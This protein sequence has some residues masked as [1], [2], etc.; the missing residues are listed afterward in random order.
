MKI[1]KT[2]SIALA[3][4]MMAGLP[5]ITKPAIAQGAAAPSAAQRQAEITFWTSIKDSKN[6]EEYKAYLEAFPN[7][8]FAALARLRIKQL[9]SAPAAPSAPP[10]AAPP[11][12][13]QPSAPPPPPQTAQPPAPPPP[14]TEPPKTA[15]PP[16]APPAPPPTVAGPPEPEA[17]PPSANEP[18]A[19][20]PA[21]PPPS[22]SPPV[23]QA[24][25]APPQQTSRIDYTN[26]EFLRELQQKLYDLNYAVSRVTGVFDADTYKSILAV[27]RN[28]RHPQ[29]GELTESE[30][31]AIQRARASNVWGAIA[32]N[33]NST[34]AFVYKR[35]SRSEAES[36]AR[37][38]CLRRAGRKAKCLILAAKDNQCIAMAKYRERWGKSTYF[39][40]R[41]NRDGTLDEARRSAIADCGKQ[42]RSRGNC[43]P[44][45]SFCANGS[46]EGQDGQ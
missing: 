10:A 43:E 1:L 17:G 29:T 24:Q 31:R 45:R 5:A 35:A 46:H 37:A 22:G 7:G 44:V 34:H 9:A 21:A 41:V 30:W 27:Q 18:P 39:G 15:Q 14:P 16:S 3:L 28:L 8:L 13:A 11:R 20:A 26:A 2:A 19:G 36:A 32:Y 38:A 23:R 33:A 40:V 42:E 4:G 12:T 25:P 6:A